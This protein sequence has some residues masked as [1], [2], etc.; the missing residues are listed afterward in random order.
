MNKFYIIISLLFFFVGFS[1]NNSFYGAFESNGV[2]YSENES[3]DFEKKFKSNN[4]FNLNYLIG[5]K[6]KFDLQ[7]ESYLPGRLQNFSNNL[8]DTY[9]STLSINYKTKK[10]DFSVGSI[11]EQFGSGLILR[12]WE[13]RQLGINNSIWGVRTRYESDKIDI[14]LLAGYQKKGREISTGK[15]LG[16]D[17]EISLSEDLQFGLSYVGRFEDITYDFG[18]FTNLFSSRLDY[19]SDSFYMNYEYISKSKDGI[20]QFGNVSENF[21]KP[22]NAHSLNF[23]VYK[24][25]FGFD[26][27]FRRLENMGYFS[28]RYEASGDFLETSINYLPALTKQHD[29]LLVQSSLSP[30][31]FYDL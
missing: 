20:V 7:L 24:S 17:T 11:Y 18:D 3:K 6:W 30:I 10:F 12:T 23:G 14:K 28:D 1:Q 2:Y 5:N 26:M 13:D 15:I 21:V 22:G 9:L 16:L 31:V 27:T 4:Y 19:Y 8:E 25:G 29:Y